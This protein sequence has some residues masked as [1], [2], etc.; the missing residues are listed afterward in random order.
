MNGDKGRQIN[1]SQFKF[2]FKLAFKLQV[3]FTGITNLLQ[4]TMKVTKIPPPTSVQFAARLRSWCVVSWDLVSNTER[5]SV[6]VIGLPFQRP[7]VR[8]PSVTSAVLVF[9]V[10]LSPS[11]QFPA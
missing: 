7:W 8:I 1:Y 6:A 4:F 9:L 10:F 11:G 3:Y 2:N 5:I